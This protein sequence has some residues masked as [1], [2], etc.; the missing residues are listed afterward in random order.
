MSAGSLPAGRGRG[1]W[2]LDQ[3]RHVLCPTLTPPARLPPRLLCPTPHTPTPINAVQHDLSLYLQLLRPEGKLILVGLSPEPL[4]LPPFAVAFGEPT[5]PQAGILL[6]V[7]AS[8]RQ[9]TSFPPPPPR[10]GRKIVSG[11]AIGSIKETQEM[12]DF[13]SQHSITCMIERIGIDEINGAM[14]RMEAGQVHYRFVVD[15]QGSLVA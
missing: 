15:V 10:P 11:S 4:A 3:P 14:Q 1:G 12:L 2:A 8:G 6:S 7:H 5:L 13:C 9:L